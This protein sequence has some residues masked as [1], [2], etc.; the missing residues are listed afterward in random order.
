[1]FISFLERLKYI[2][3]CGQKF[4]KG[5]TR[6]LSTRIGLSA[7]CS[8]GESATDVRYQLLIQEFAS[9]DSV[10]LSKFLTRR[11]TVSLITLKYFATRHNYGAHLSYCCTRRP[12]S[13][14]SAA[15]I[16]HTRSLDFSCCIKNSVQRDPAETLGAER[17]ALT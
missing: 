15:S 5:R 2:I 17:H 4:P 6:S 16:I 14:K 9:G 13:I 7:R 3:R 1:M 8:C 12:S 11:K 10:I